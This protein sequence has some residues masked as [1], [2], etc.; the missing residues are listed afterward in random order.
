M[1]SVWV[2]LCVENSTNESASNLVEL[3]VLRVA[4]KHPSALKLSNFFMGHNIFDLIL[5]L[6]LL[7]FV[8]NIGNE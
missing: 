2:E 7:L 3:I 8:V 6:H 1:K 4:L 5:S